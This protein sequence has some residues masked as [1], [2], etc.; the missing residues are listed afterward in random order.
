MYIS[1][2]KYNT[3]NGLKIEISHIGEIY[4]QIYFIPRNFMFS[5]V[6]LEHY[7]KMLQLQHIY[8]YFGFNNFVII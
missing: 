4:L 6:S 7:I 2:F 1:E 8:D 5:K 3:V